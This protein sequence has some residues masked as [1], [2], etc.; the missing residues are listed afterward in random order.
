MKSRRPF[1]TAT[2]G[3]IG[4]LALA[5]GYAGLGAAQSPP[6]RIAFQIATGSTSGTYFPVGQMIAGVISHPPGVGRCEREG[7]CG[8]PGLIATARASEGSI[9]N[10]LAVDSG[11]ADS[12][13]AQAD[14]VAEAV[15][16][17][18]VFKSAG[19]RTKLRV[20]ANLYPENVH[21]VVRKDAGIAGVADLRGRRVSISTEGSGTIATARALLAAYGLSER[22]IMPNYD[23]ADRAAQ[24]LEAGEL[25]AFFFV[26]GAPVTLISELVGRGA[27]ELAPIDGAGRERLL[28]EQAHLQAGEIPA[29]TY[30]GYDRIPT[31]AVGALWIVNADVSDDL[32]YA[33]TRALLNPANRA[34]LV[35]GHDKGRFIAPETAVRG[36]S[37]PFHPG[38]VRYYA[39]I[40]LVPEG[41]EI[42]RQPMPI[43]K[44]EIPS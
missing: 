34:R 2:A 8:P 11:R 23:S 12:A 21:L 20:I 7:V 41:P 29:G 36:A 19:P 40:G 9:A 26:G 16:G 42:P 27:A 32:V 4:L 18:G 22:R 30:A 13:L 6:A 43:A 17:R 37:A 15:A 35:A 33:L 44:P 39:E 28:A 24:L 38:A 3:A 31:V 10:T 5:L 1:W 14:V 25:D